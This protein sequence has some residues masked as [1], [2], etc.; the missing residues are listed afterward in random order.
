MNVEYNAIAIDDI[1]DLIEGL[2]RQ[3]NEFLEQV[4]KLKGEE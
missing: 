4:R 3:S 2:Y 1:K